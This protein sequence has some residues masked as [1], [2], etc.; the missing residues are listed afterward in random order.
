MSSEPKSK[1]MIPSDVEVASVAGT[2]DATFKLIEDLFDVSISLSDRTINLFG[3][4]ISCDGASL[5]ISELLRALAANEVVDEAGLRR[6]AELVRHGEYSPKELSEDVILSFRG[7]SIR[8]MTAGQKAYID[9]IRSSDITFCIGPAGSGKTYLAMALAV[10]ALQ[11]GTFERLVLTRPV[12][13][14][15]ENLGFL[16]G[17]LVEKIDPYMQPLYDALFDMM[18]PKVANSLLDDSTIEVAPLAYMRGRTLNRAFVIL[19]EAQNATGPQMKMFLTRLGKGSKMVVTGDLGQSDLPGGASGLREA[20]SVLKGIEEI[21]LVHLAAQD[22]VR[23]P[24]VAKIVRAYE[25]RS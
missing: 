16:P 10:A 15:G 17:T 11:N 24:L 8:P 25:V 1:L 4:D 3:N 6:I 14:A 20:I 21:S 18:E 23:N 9:S 5:V 7:R 22:V 2:A 19:D 12:L 13:E